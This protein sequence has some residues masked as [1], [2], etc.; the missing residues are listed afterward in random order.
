[1]I[2]STVY[3]NSDEV[4][5]DNKYEFESIGRPFFKSLGDAI[6][7]YELSRKRQHHPVLKNPVKSY[8]KR[9]PT[10]KR[11]SIIEADN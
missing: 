8:D 7:K 4:L 11:P 6:Y 9:D 5:N 10:D 3:V 1:M 2:A